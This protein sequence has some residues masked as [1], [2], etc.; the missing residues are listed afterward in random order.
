VTV[1]EFRWLSLAFLSKTTDQ[2]DQSDPSDQSDQSDQSDPSDPSYLVWSGA[3][4]VGFWP[5]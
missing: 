5:A 3:S 1:E 2:S 4:A